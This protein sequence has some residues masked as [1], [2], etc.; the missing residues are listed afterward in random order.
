[1]EPHSETEILN[2]RFERVQ[3]SHRVQIL[4]KQTKISVTNSWKAKSFTFV[5]VMNSRNLKSFTSYRARLQSEFTFLPHTVTVLVRLFVLT[6]WFLLKTWVWLRVT[7]NGP[8][9]NLEWL[10]LISIKPQSDLV[11]VSLRFNHWSH[12][13]CS[14]CDFHFWRTFKK[15]KFSPSCN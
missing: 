8:N 6:W 1:M 2:F 5:K 12:F 3:R 13:S 9:Q 14:F 15:F 4:E 10:S 11:S 7:S